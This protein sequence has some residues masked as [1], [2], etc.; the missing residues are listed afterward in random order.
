[1]QTRDAVEKAQEA[2]KVPTVTALART[3]LRRS[4][5]LTLEK[6]G[7]DSASEEAM[8]S[9]TNIVETCRTVRSHLRRCPWLTAILPDLE[10]IVEDVKTFANAARRSYA[11]PTDFELTLKRFNLTTA[12]LKPHVRP[13]IPKP[14]RQPVYEPLQI[15]TATDASLPIL[16]EELS[17]KT[18]KK[19]KAHVPTAFPSFPSIHTYK[20][21]P[22]VKEYNPPNDD[23]GDFAPEPASQ[24]I[25]QFPTPDDSQSQ[26]Q[27]QTQIQARGKRPL[28][29][30]E[31]PHGDPKKIREAAAKEAKYGEQALRKLMRASKIARQKEVWS[32]AQRQPQRRLRQELWETSMKDFIEEDVRAKGLQ[33]EDGA[34]HGALG[35]FEIADHSTIVNAEGRYYRKEVQR[36]GMRKPVGSGEVGIGK[37]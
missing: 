24:S 19:S 23:W 29:P 14:K 37:P 5:A 10:S 8:E 35:K 2:A 4:I 28:A 20:Y 31:I 13:P 7:F 33:V 34:I 3:G 16:G 6:V 26:S 9:L 17:G 15:E 1:M 27:T 36:A 30:E 11:I 32:T 21:T 12:A 18:D 22:E 25:P